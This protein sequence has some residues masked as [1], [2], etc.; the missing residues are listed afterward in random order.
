MSIIQDIRD[1]YAKVAV[2]AIALALIGF[3]LTD[4]FSGRG[5]ASMGGSNTLGSVNGTSIKADA[6]GRKVEQ[7]EA[8]MRNQGY[9]AA[10]VTSQ[11]VDQV[12]TQEVN[13]IL[14]ED[15]AGKLGLTIGK[16]ELG[17]LLYGA[18]APPDLKQQ[19]SDSSGYDP[20]RAKQRIDQMMK[21]KS[22]PQEQKDNFNAYVDQ[23]RDIRLSQ[24]FVS[25]MAN[26]TNY[27]RWFIEKQ[28]ADN[29]QIGKISL[30]RENYGSI[31]DSSVTVTDKE[32]QDYINKYKDLFKQEESRS[33]AYVTFSAAPT[34]ADS[35]M[36]S[37][38]LLTYKPEFD[39]TTDVKSFL[40]R[41]SATPMVD[42][43]Y[44]LKDVSAAVKDTIQKLAVNQVAG[45]YLDGGEYRLAKLIG[46]KTLPDSVKCRHI[47]LGVTDRS[48]N[49]IMPDSVAKA[50]VDS[51]ER[52]IRGGANF[53]SLEAKYTTDQAAHADKG[54]MTFA[55]STIQSEGFAKEFAQFILFD[56]KPGD[57]KVVK[58]QFG[59][60]YI[61]I[62][63]HINPQPSYKIAYFSLPIIA[64]PETENKAQEEANQFAADARDRKGFDDLYEKTQK[65]KN[66]VKG[67]GPNIKPTSA[68]IPGVGFSRAMV[69]AIYDAK[70]NEVL[71]PERI[72]NN[73]V[74]AVVT[75]IFEEGTKSP[76][77]ARPEVEPVLRN[78]KK[79]EIIKKKIGQVTTLDAAAAAL[80]GKQIEVIDSVRMNGQGKIS[81][82]PKVV[83]ATFNPNNKMKVVPEAIEGSNGVYV[84]RVDSVGS[85][86]STGGTVP[87]QRNNLYT[88][89]KQYLQNPQAPAYPMNTLM[90][91]ATIKDRRSKRY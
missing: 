59:W 66:R 25:L 10:A 42:I 3:I 77:T 80:G 47:L 91:V 45:P 82:E 16:K 78:R 6:F 79:A 21:D 90:K 19:L 75:D 33:I 12:W 62:M 18:S 51:V 30:V 73:Y 31:A 35:Q 28:D 36:V 85:T 41:S 20:V 61:E 83:G 5:R 69:R 8:T 71:K 74:V 24:K 44:G 17:D 9:P 48:G 52:A 4:Y 27:P 46:V 49:P 64:S 68:Q 32:I 14:L 50:K 76:A 67:I 86:P 72:D 89:T 58:T 23:L 7:A 63:S 65:P 39:T 60:H 53:D 70:L 11:A 34:A 26:S 56:G 81:Y 43:Y 84:M 87:D 57:K 38:Q 55:S 1:K 15:E 37:N 13:N 88:Q 54:V 40:A 2:V 29:S 22:V